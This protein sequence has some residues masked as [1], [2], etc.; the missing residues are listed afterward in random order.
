MSPGEASD[1]PERHRGGN[2]HPE[3]LSA[4]SS[5]LHKTRSRAQTRAQEQGQLHVL[6]NSLGGR[7]QAGW[8]VGLEAWGA[9]TFSRQNMESRCGLGFKN[10][11][12]LGL[13]QV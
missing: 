12:E 9:K 8:E 5:P 4:G 3:W 1:A 11:D 6:E 10:K 7:T 13:D 2:W